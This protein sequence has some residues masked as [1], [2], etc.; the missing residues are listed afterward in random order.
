M[1]DIIEFHRAH[2]YVINITKTND[3]CAAH[4]PA[5]YLSNPPLSS[6]YILYKINEGG[7]E[8]TNEDYSCQFDIVNYAKRHG[9][10]TDVILKAKTLNIPHKLI[11]ITD[12]NVVKSSLAQILP[13]PTLEEDQLKEQLIAQVYTDIVLGLFDYSSANKLGIL[14]GYEDLSRLIE[15]GGLL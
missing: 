3:G 11:Y 12:N 10:V 2:K 6:K 8:C 14:R 13:R 9:I 15:S 7:F 5:N 1:N 4:F